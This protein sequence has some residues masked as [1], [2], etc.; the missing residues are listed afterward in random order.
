MAFTLQG[1]GDIEK[2][3]TEKTGH[4][5]LDIELAHNLSWE[6]RV[7]LENESWSKGGH[8]ERMSRERQ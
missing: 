8:P 3:N 1:K 4:L 2:T 6:V 5:S 7:G